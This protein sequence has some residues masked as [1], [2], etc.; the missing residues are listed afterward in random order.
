MFIYKHD[1]HN[2]AWNLACEEYLFSSA[3]ADIFMLW[4][5]ASAVIVGRHQ[6]T[7]AEIDLDFV[8]RNNIT[9]IRRTTGGGAVFHDVGNINYS[10]IA[11]YSGPIDFARFSAPIISALSVF[12]IN[13]EL[14]GRNDIT[15]DGRKISGAAQT[16]KNGRI[17]HHGT[18]LY[19]ADLSRLAG[20]LRVN[21]KKYEGRAISSVSSRVMNIS[22]KL[23]N[24]PSADDFFNALYLKMFEIFQDSSPFSPSDEDI[25][26]IQS[27]KAERYDLE[28]WNYGTNQE[29]N[30]KNSIKTTGGI[31]EVQLFADKG[32]IK[33]CSFKGDFFSAADI[34]ILEAKMSGVPH[35]YEQ[36]AEVLTDEAIK[37]FFIG[38]D[39]HQVLNTLF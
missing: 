31:I 20:A 9:V 11:N 2:P 24:A 10:Y 19:N 18:L 4:R 12:G 37:T 28:A 21:E 22:E 29:Y 33:T 14:S 23:E 32:I 16:L 3:S 27:L 34:S 6:N 26:A 8:K 13:A 38:F 39:R 1:S 15:V 17:L 25:L 7:Y 30:F 35:T 5:N 36:V